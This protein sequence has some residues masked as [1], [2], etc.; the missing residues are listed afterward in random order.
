MKI[1]IPALTGIFLILL[2]FLLHHFP[3]AQ[4]CVILNK[5]SI[6]A[7]IEIGFFNTDYL[8]PVP[9]FPPVSAKSISTIR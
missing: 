1:K 8:I 3:H 5:V 6:G 4:S 9:L 2:T 7:F